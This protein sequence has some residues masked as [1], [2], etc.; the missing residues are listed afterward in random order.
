MNSS[1]ETI[2]YMSIAENRALNKLNKLYKHNQIHR[3]N[4]T[5]LYYLIKNIGPDDNHHG[6]SHALWVTYNAMK[7]LLIGLE[8]YPTDI[9]YVYLNGKS[10]MLQAITM[11]HDVL[12]NKYIEKMNKESIDKIRTQINISLQNLE[13][14]ENEISI[15]E[16]II[17]LKKISSE[18]DI[19][20]CEPNKEIKKM[21]HEWVSIADM[22][23]AIGLNGTIRCWR[24]I[25]DFG[26]T[27]YKN[28]NFNSDM[29]YLDEVIK[30]Y[31]EKLL[32]VYT[33]YISK[34]FIKDIIKPLHDEM[35]EFYNKYHTGEKGKLSCIRKIKSLMGAEIYLPCLENILD[36]F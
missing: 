23:E 29:D 4:L 6:P 1:Y 21:L 11:L 16:E 33:N 22:I 5:T 26:S 19:V 31:D 25:D 13:F 17:S 10:R 14:T 2:N 34:D 30:Y 36:K 35:L 32:K 7:L 3:E 24:C 20:F 15:I 9:T 8:K 18:N 27:I 28:K 12:D